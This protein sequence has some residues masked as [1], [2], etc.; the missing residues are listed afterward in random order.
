[1]DCFDCRAE[2]IESDE[3]I[4]HLVLTLLTSDAFEGYRSGVGSQVATGYIL[5]SK[6]N[7]IIII[8][9]GIASIDSQNEVS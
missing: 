6:T 7:I 5:G 2:I 4:S 8:G 1:M 9:I 3:S